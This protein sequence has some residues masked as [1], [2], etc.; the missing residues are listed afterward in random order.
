MMGNNARECIFVPFS[1][2]HVSSVDCVDCDAR[3]NAREVKKG[4]ETVLLR[5]RSL[6][7]K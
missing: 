4:T 3:E 2:T 5:P 7:S 6:F 1:L